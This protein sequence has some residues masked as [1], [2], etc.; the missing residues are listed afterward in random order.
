MAVTAHPRH[1]VRRAQGGGDPADDLFQHTVSG[2]V[3]ARVVDLLQVVDIDHENANGVEIEGYALNEYVEG[4]GVQVLGDIW[5]KAQ[6]LYCG[7][8]SASASGLDAN[9]TPPRNRPS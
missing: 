1:K 9:F 5:L 3:A 8:Y 4:K 6:R 2:G 7:K